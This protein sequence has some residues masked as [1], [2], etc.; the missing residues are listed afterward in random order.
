MDECVLCNS[1]DENIIYKNSLFR[2]ILVNDEFYPGFVRLI[3]NEHIKEMSF[4]DEKDSLKI[5]D[6][7]LKIEKILLEVYNPDKINLASFGNVVPHVHWHIIPRFKIDRHY[8]NPVW[9]EVT[10]SSYKPSQK[11]LDCEKKLINK[12][13]DVIL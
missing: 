10:H 7:I 2:I 1:V 6:A 3:I 12:L 13:H 9:G 8:P 11:L 4:L 5:F